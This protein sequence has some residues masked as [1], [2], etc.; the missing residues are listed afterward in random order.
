MRFSSLSNSSDKGVLAEILRGN[1]P[2]ARNSLALRH[3]FL[4]GRRRITRCRVFVHGDRHFPGA[5]AIRVDDAPCRF[6]IGDC[7]QVAPR[8]RFA[9]Y[10]GKETINGVYRDDYLARKDGIGRLRRTVAGDD[11]CP[12]AVRERVSITTMNTPANFVSVNPFRISLI[13][14]SHID[15]LPEHLQDHG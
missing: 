13:L 4:I 12:S 10:F 2:E 5:I 7:G 9:R 14:R 1:W 11:D 8:A 6:G 3:S 15:D